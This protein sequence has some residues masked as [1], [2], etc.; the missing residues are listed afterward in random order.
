MFGLEVPFAE[1]ILDNHSY[2][3]L[4]P[5]KER[6][7]NNNLENEIYMQECIMCFLIYLGHWEY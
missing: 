3:T 2:C 4:L 7:K 5:L 1:Y 6:K